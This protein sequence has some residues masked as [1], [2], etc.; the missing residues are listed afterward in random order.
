MLNKHDKTIL[1]R[2]A[3]H[4]EFSGPK[5][6]GGWRQSS[7]HAILV[8]SIIAVVIV[9]IPLHKCHRDGRAIASCE[10]ATA[11]VRLDSAER[12]RFGKKGGTVASANRKRSRDRCS[13]GYPSGG[14]RWNRHRFQNPVS[15]T[16]L[17]VA[18]ESIL[19]QAKASESVSP[20]KPDTESVEFDRD[21]MLQNTGGDRM[22]VRKLIEMFQVESRRQLDAV[23]DAVHAGDGAMIKAAAHVLKGSVALFGASGCVAEVLKLEKMG[24]Q[25]ELRHVETQFEAICRLPA[26]LSNALDVYLAE[27]HSE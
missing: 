16:E 2:N 7:R 8:R 3:F 11:F 12:R 25:N 21:A 17:R 15:M 20:D 4:F 10:T 22:F 24:E 1:R 23:G 13:T 9:D 19:N 6:A 26:G 27:E 14:P 5:R 18:I